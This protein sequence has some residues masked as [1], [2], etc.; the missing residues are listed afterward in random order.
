MILKLNQELVPVPI[1]LLLIKMDVQDILQKM[2]LKPDH[3][4]APVDGIHGAHAVFL[5]NNMKD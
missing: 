4:T 3:A 1:V 5:A 2:E